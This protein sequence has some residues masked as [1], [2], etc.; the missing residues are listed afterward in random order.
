PASAPALPDRAEFLASIVRCAMDAII[1]VDESQPV[2]LCNEAAERIFG[3]PA[4]EAVGA[5]L[6]RF[7]PERH[8]RAHAPHARGFGKTGVTMRTMGRLGTLSGLRTSGEEFPIEAS[9]SQAVIGGGRFYTVILRD[10][11]EQHKLRAQLLQA[12]KMEGVGQFVGGVAHDF[13]NL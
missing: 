10:V 7:I 2:V 8:R 4:R 1:T 3:V 12:Q 5:P 6:D 11:T 13:N 9:I